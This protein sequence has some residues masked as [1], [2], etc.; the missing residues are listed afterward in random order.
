MAYLTKKAEYLS[1]CITGPACHW[2]LSTDLIIHF[3]KKFFKKTLIDSGCQVWRSRM[4][5]TSCI[6]FSLNYKFQYCLPN[7]NTGLKIPFKNSGTVI[8]LLFFFFSF[9]E[10]VFIF[11]GFK[12]VSELLKVCSIC[13]FSFLKISQDHRHH[14]FFLSSTGSS[15]YLS[16]IQSL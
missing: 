14:L 1:N 10:L 13:F 11:M 7:P 8:S 12:Q 16:S 5:S 3:M 9:E 15:I 6:K 2:Y 4:H